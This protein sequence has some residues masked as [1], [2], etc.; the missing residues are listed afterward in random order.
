MYNKFLVYL[1]SNKPEDVISASGVRFRK[2]IHPALMRLF[3]LFSKSKLHIFRKEEVPPGV[4]LIYAS[5]HGFRD[6][7]PLALH[8]TGEHAYML[9]AS[10]PIFFNTFDGIGLWLNGVLLFDRKEKD[11]RAA[12]KP[13]MLRAIDLGANLLIFPEGVWNK[14][15]ATTVQKLYPGVY[16]VAKEKHALVVPIASIN[17]GP[18]SYAIMEKPFDIS[19]YDR[20]EG[21]KVL[22]D[23]LATA[24]YELM[25]KY[26][27]RG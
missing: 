18:D 15:P 21:M 7:I 14:E 16:D 9:F 27:T 19:Q 26:S 8:I 24:K 5:T 6:D 1:L 11:S 10:L 12:S 17:E 13:K 22:R 23:K 2:L 25:E 20:E 3:P 4:P